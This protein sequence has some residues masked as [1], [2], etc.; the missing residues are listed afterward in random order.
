LGLF[1]NTLPLR[2]RVSQHQAS[3]FMLKPLQAQQ[4]E[5]Q[6][7][8]YSSLLDIQGW[9]DMPR[10]VPLFESIFVFEESARRRHLSSHEEQCRIP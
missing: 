5:L 10:G 1:I 9:S 6:Q 2:V 8:E 3:A 4:S 7:Y